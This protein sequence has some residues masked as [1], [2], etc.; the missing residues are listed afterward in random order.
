LWS[1]GIA[2]INA[3]SGY[4]IFGDDS[5]ESQRSSLT[6]ANLFFSTWAA[7]IYSF[8]LAT[9][10]FNASVTNAD[11]VLMLVVSCA[12]VGATFAYIEDTGPEDEWGNV[13]AMAQLYSCVD[14]ENGCRQVAFGFYLGVICGVLS[15]VMIAL[16]RL[17]PCFHLVSGIAA[18]C[19]WGAGVGIITFASVSE[20]AS[21]CRTKL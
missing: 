7:L 13:D 6:Q 15:L 12:L 19:G 11:W 16:C 14:V 1:L 2:S 5:Q 3:F 9:S 17:G 4:D 18:L 21:R 10:W 8:L 20:T